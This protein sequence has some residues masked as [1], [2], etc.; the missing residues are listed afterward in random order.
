MT[1]QMNDLLR[2]MGVSEMPI[3]EKATPP[4]R[5]KTRTPRRNAV[6]DVDIAEYA[7][8]RYLSK[9]TLARLAEALREDRRRGKAR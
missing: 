3:V 8:E 6:H 9:V 2:E 4:E 5:R 7:G 1:S